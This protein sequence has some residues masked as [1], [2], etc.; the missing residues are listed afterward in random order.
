MQGKWNILLFYPQNYACSSILQEWDDLV[1]NLENNNINLIGVSNDSNLS[2]QSW[3][4]RS[5]EGGGGGNMGFALIGD[6][7]AELGEKF[8]IVK[9]DN[10]KF[11]PTTI[12]V[13]PSGKL[14]STITGI[15][16]EHVLNSLF[17]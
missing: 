16:P 6:T 12:L 8:N 9:A 5:K 1:Q 17:K 13:S 10:G 11:M 3:N 14:F 7:K 15:S 4:A 2:H